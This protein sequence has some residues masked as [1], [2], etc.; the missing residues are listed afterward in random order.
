MHE[1]KIGVSKFASFSKTKGKIDVFK[2]KQFHDYYE[3]YL[4]LNGKVDFLNDHLRK[5]IAPY[6]LV[7]IPPNVYHQ[8][9]VLADVD[10]YERCVL[11]VDKNL[12]EK[13]VIKDAVNNKEILV[14]NNQDRIVKNFLHL[15]T[16][17]DTI[18]K[19]DFSIIL[20]EVLKL[21]IGP[22]IDVNLERDTILIE[23]LREYTEM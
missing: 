8:F 6:T 23:N 5:Q 16:I 2:E 18:T 12:L 17:L 19:E 15:S 1:K 9:I 13:S 10:N 4:L 3:F 14:L 7:I 11:N 20:E 21:I 22:M